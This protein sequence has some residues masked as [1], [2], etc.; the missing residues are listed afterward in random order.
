[1]KKIVLSIAIAA[2]AAAA[3]MPAQARDSKMMLP[4]EGAMADNDAQNRLGDSV[5]FYFGN[6]KTPKV[7]QKLGADQTSQKTNSF[8]KSAEKACNWAFLSAMLRLQAR[9]QELGANA[10]INIASNYKNVEVMSNDQYECHDGKMVTGVA[11]KG[12]FVKIK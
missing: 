1:M 5:K 9:A 11:L 2:A 8:G 4:I 12:D 10:V 6:Q 3:G 7:L